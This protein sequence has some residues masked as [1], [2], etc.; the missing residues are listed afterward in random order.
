MK[1]GRA[2]SV[3]NVKSVEEEAE[4]YVISGIATTPKPDRYGDVVNPMGAKFA[5]PMPLLWQHD[6]R[7]P[8]GFVDFAKPQKNGIPFEAKIP[9][10]LE[11]GKLKD[12]IDEAVHSVKYK[13]I[14]GVSIGF[15]ALESDVEFLDGGGVRYDQ[16]EWLELSL[17]TIPANSDATITNIKALDQK[18]LTASGRNSSRTV[19][20]KKT[21]GVTAKL[22]KPQE[23][24]AMN[25]QEQLKQFEAKRAALA[26]RLETIMKGAA[27][28]GRT[29]NEAEEEEYD[30]LELEVKTVDT[31]L[32]RLRR[33]EVS[34]M[35]S[36]QRIVAPQDSTQGAESAAALRSPS[37][38]VTEPKLDK[39]IE[40]ARYAM[41]LGVSKGN[42]PQAELIAK[43]RFPNS[44]RIHTVLKAAVSAG[45]TTATGWAAEL[46]EY[47]QFVGDFVEFLRPQTIIGKFG[48][49]GVPSLRRIPF[50]VHIRGESAGGSGY[51]VGQGAPKPLTRSTF[52]DAYLGW[53]KVA[54]IAV[55]SEE[56]MRFSNPSA[57]AIVRDTL[58]SALIARLDIDFVLPGKA[59][60]A[61]VS[62]AS[63]TN[64]VVAISSSGNNAAA[65]RA[66]VS[67]VMS[68]YIAANITPTTAVWIMPS[69]VALALSLMRNALGQKEFPDITMMGGTF[70]GLPVIASEYVPT[71]TG[72]AI[73]ILANASDIWLADDGQVVLD[74]SR[75]A[76][77]QMDDAPT[78]NSAVPTA[79]TM[80]S[81]F[82]TNSVA[83]RAERWINWQKRRPAA[84]QVLDDVNWAP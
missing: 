80:V 46:V 4:H 36:A 50:N 42:L 41:C 74:A 26:E 11:P 3:L 15:Q 27:D 57:E 60:V 10:V 58:A 17:V 14:A 59:L 7:H 70:E 8:V 61:N 32:V 75:E 33:L 49:G 29:L 77:L 73:V 2:Y 9:K 34:N 12:R 31:H 25:V 44:P 40:F 64:G 63:I 66:D 71:V 84:V 39:G 67:A 37:I 79:T 48:V 21:A 24:H 16:W 19:S 43:Q 53:A 52:T 72:G 54:N 62:P 56:L 6:A 69:T 20:I 18:L 22:N 55:L 47:N 78:N 38:V 51:W 83:M 5:L 23:G 30:G 28:E 65:V 35:K 1:T 13:L 45:T 82:Q 68:A 76:S 81:M